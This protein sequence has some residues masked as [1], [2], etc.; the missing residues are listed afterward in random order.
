MARDSANNQLYIPAYGNGGFRAFQLD[1]EGLPRDRQADFITSRKSIFGRRSVPP[2]NAREATF[3]GAAAIFDS[4]TERFFT[5]DRFANRILVYDAA[6]NR[7]AQF[8]EAELVIG[9]PDASS[10]KRGLGPN[11]M[12]GIANAV[13]DEENQRS[14]VADVPNNRIMIFDVH[15]DRLSN[16]PSAYDV[17]G[18]DDFESRDPGLGPDKFTRPSSLAYDPEN[19]RLFVSDRGNNRVLIFDA[20]PENFEGFDAAV[21]VMGQPDFVSREPRQSLDEFKAENIAY[22]WTNQ[23]LFVSEDLEHRIMVYDAHPD[24]VGGLTK[25]LA[26]IGQPD[27]FSTQPAVSDTRIA[28][29]RIT[30]DSAREKLYISEG[31][32]AGN[33]ITVWDIS[34]ANLR[35]GMSAL[36]VIGHETVDGKADFFNRMPQG[37]IDGR[38]L[39]AAR[40]V[41]LDS[42]DHRL[43]VSDEYN[44][45]VVVWQLDELNR[46]DRYAA[47]WV[48][49]QPDLNTSL[50][51]APSARNLTVPI[52]AAYDTSTKRFFVGDGY[53]NRIMV[54][55]AAPGQLASGMAASVVIGQPDF[56]TV[57]RTAGQ[58]GINFGVRMGRG[59]ASNFLPMGFAVDEVGQRLFVSDGENH[60]VLIYDIRRDVLRNGAEAIGVIGQPDFDLN[61]P[62]SDARGLN[63]PGHL[64]YDPVNDRL[65][66]VDAKHK[67]VLAFDVNAERFENNPAAVA[68]IGKPNFQTPPAQGPGG[69]PFAAPPSRPLPVSGQGFATPNGIAHDPLRQLLYIA[70]GGG[71]FRI[72][73]DRILVF[74]VD[75]DRFENGATAIAT[76]GA[77][78]A[79]T[80]A[81][82][83]WGGA[84]PVPGQFRVR[85]TRGIALDH[86]NGRL[87][88]TGSFESRV[89]QFNFPRA[90]WNYRIDPAGL[91][92]FATLDAADFGGRS[93][94]ASVSVAHLAATTTSAPRSVVIYSASEQTVDQSTERHSRRL[95]NEAAVTPSPLSM[96][97][98]IFVDGGP[99][100]RHALYIYN[101]GRRDSDLSMTL[102]GEQGVVLQ[103]WDRTVAAGEQQSLQVESLGGA[104]PQNATLTITTRTPVAMTAV[105]E[106]T[107]GRDETILAPA[108]MMLDTDS[109]LRMTV[110]Y[111]VNGGGQRSRLILINAG[112][113]P[114]AG[115]VSFYDHAGQR[116]SLG[117]A[118]NALRYEIPPHSSW[119]MESDGVGTGVQRGYAVV[120]P[121]TDTVPHSVV[122][123]EHYQGEV[124]TNESSTSG[125]IATLLEF[126]VDLRPTLIR[127]GEIDTR[128]VLV[129]SGVD[130]PATARV[131]LAGQEIS[132]ITLDPGT[133]MIL[134]IRDLAGAAAHGIVTVASDNAIVVAA[135]QITLNIRSESIETELPAVAANEFVPFV[136]NGGGLSTEFRLGN[137]SKNAATGAL[138]FLLP[139]GQPATGTILR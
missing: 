133:Q 3:P 92:S 38:S 69:G 101:P 119:T 5:I 107:N 54:Y 137:M 39:A 14:F 138:E 91:Q 41:T 21:A 99:Q 36:D 48:L 87:F 72:S 88:A 20:D 100:R 45:R 97:A 104:V 12:G 127:H 31:Y 106:S 112:D 68:V 83:T 78:D 55:D 19:E 67:R 47:Q 17:I 18:Q 43:F 95:I 134:S 29:P 40:A 11:R 4:S 84:D 58:A 8:P 2:A 53:H 77:P 108:P 13:L 90:D 121:A 25:A 32:P 120:E 50:M 93:D 118:S 26:V 85:D 51:G 130:G 37:H 66:V 63:D 27:A 22:D 123:I 113:K 6:E 117:T 80:P 132:A 60:R 129:N 24:R 115:N 122:M 49:G 1:A 82:R 76:L 94:E 30:V 89:V 124:W 116:R 135:R 96:R 105:R 79:T 16:D 7:L 62:G 15:P 131:S 23:R 59:I 44:H 109:P 34:S 110:P 71:T 35:T 136:P 74:D 52:G 126:A 114:A 57:T 46:I 65:F 9:Q 139:S 10:A 111:F 98:T 86:T 125:A 102:R 42:V 81:A 75:P 73:A 28:M 103:Q 64:A 128:L 33:R 56:E 70:D 61:A